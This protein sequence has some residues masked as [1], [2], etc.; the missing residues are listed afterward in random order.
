MSNAIESQGFKFYIAN[1]GESPINYVEVGGLTSFA[2]FDGQANEIDTTTLQSTAKER[3]MGLQDFGTCSFEANFREDD[4]GQ[5]AMRSAKASRERKLFQ[6]VMSS[7]L[8]FSFGGY[9][10]GAPANGAVDAKVDSS[11]NVLVDG[12]VAES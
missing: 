11:F 8:I 10:Q 6:A 2:L 3:I 9:V 1:E 4:P 12:D 7:G 5:V